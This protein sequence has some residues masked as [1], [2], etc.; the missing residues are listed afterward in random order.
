MN[1][2]DILKP[3]E[4]LKSLHGVRGELFI[5]SKD[6]PDY[7]Y[8]RRLEMR[9][10]GDFTVHAKYLHLDRIRERV[11]LKIHYKD[12]KFLRYE[13]QSEDEKTKGCCVPLFGGNFYKFTSVV[14]NSVK[15]KISWGKGLLHFPFMSW[16]PTE[17]FTQ[18]QSGKSQSFRFA[19]SDSLT[20]VYC[21]LKVIEQTDKEISIEIEPKKKSELFPTTRLRYQLPSGLL[22]E[23]VGYVLPKIQ[24][25]SK[26]V[27]RP[28]RL[29]LE[30]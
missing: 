16:L 19:F 12:G 28:G 22:L 1:H 3:Q 4:V 30:Y 29:V 2:I 26:W 24:V 9:A 10:S 7:Y 25:D 8:E 17:F 21:L 15:S 11:S 20:V 27:S 5:S 13:I 23:S 14:E 18:L 6:R